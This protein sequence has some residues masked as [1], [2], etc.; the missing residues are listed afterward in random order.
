M[1]LPVPVL[2]LAP[3][4]LLHHFVLGGVLELLNLS[5][6]MLVLLSIELLGS[7]SIDEDK[8]VLFQFNTIAT[9]AWDGIHWQPEFSHTFGSCRLFPAKMAVEIDHQT[10]GE[11]EKDYEKKVNCHGLAF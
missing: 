3:F 11:E 8:F 6:R 5:L 4:L 1:C 9:L 7:D 2:N 10:K